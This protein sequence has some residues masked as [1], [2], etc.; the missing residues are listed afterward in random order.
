MGPVA[1]LAANTFGAATWAKIDAD[2]IN[3]RIVR[4]VLIFMV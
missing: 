1:L 2:S 3:K 4:L